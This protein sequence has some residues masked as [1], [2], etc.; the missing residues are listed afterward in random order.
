MLYYPTTTPTIINR[1]HL[2]LHRKEKDAK[3]P[4]PF[5]EKNKKWG[6]LF[7]RG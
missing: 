7:R 2:I 6:F 1:D 4:I 5:Q 3:R